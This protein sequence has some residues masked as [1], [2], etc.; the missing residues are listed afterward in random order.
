MPVA[1]ITGAS[2]GLGRQIALALSEDGYSVSVNYLSSSAEA[3]QLIETT[4]RNSVALRADV[5]DS[6][7][8]RAIAEEIKREFG[9]LDVIINN[10]GIAKDHLLLKQTELEWDSVIR[11]NLTAV[12]MSSGHCLRS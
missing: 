10:A 2:R 11:T 5:G 6:R 12:L 3:A 1:L 4:G 7:Q 8:V 9:R